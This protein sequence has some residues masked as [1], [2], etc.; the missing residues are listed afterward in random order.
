MTVKNLL[1]SILENYC[2]QNVYLQGTLNAKEDYPDTFITFFITD[3]DFGA[4]Y[5]NDANKSDW[6]IAVMI[7]STDPNQIDTISKGIIKDLKA[8]G[9]IPENAGH[10]IPSD[11]ETHTGWAID[12]IY[13][14]YK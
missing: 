11:V 5:D 8:A 4:F 7:Y 1:I 2:P 14:E 6:F 12:F 13:Q 10:D 3:S 9:F